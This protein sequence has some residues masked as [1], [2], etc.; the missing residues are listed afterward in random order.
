MAALGDGDENAQLVQGHACIKNQ[1]RS[2]LQEQLI[3]RIGSFILSFL[4][5]LEKIRRE[6]AE[7]RMIGRFRSLLAHWTRGIRR[8]LAGDRYHPEEHYMRGPGP[9]TRA[10][11]MGRTG[12]TGS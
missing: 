2:N 10:K 3:R 7:S 8:R 1:Y 5:K 9:K 6:I 11:S 4:V 12:A